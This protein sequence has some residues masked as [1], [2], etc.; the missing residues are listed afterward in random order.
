MDV[1]DVG[2][3]AGEEAVGAVLLVV[4][5]G[6]EVLGP[7]GEEG[8]AVEGEV[9]RVVARQDE[10]E[11]RVGGDEGPEVALEARRETG[12]LGGAAA[13]DDAVR[14]RRAEEVLAAEDRVRACLLYTSDAADE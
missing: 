7:L 12:Q 14:E 10:V 6:E 2:A 5:P 4:G 1:R 8:R 9:V 13:E 11:V 3:P